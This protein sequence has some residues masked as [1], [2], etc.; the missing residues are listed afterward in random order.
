MQSQYSKPNRKLDTDNIA[1]CT[2]FKPPKPNNKNGI[3]L[4]TLETNAR[5][6]MNKIARGES[7]NEV[8]RKTKSHRISQVS[9]D[10]D[11]TSS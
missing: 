11:Q 10:Y 6:A 9:Q 7:L 4:S 3:K 8:P 5:Q 2:S 1:S